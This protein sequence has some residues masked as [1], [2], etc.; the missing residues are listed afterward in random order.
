METYSN[1]AN[2]YGSVPT[3]IDPSVTWRIIGGNMNGLRPYGDTAA[4]MAV[5]GILCALQADTI[6]ELLPLWAHRDNPPVTTS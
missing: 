1:N 3:P 4:L 6:L 2:C 5:S